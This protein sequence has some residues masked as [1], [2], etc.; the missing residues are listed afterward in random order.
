MQIQSVVVLVLNALAAGTAEQVKGT[1]VQKVITMMNEM[2]AKGKA[3][4]EAETKIFNE[5]AEWV[6]DK[7]RE[8]GFEIKTLKT[9]IEEFTAAAELADADIA[10]LSE[11]IAELDGQI[12]TWEA[13]QKSATAVRD[14]ENAEYQKISKDYK[15]SLDALARAISVLES[16]AVD[17]PQAE[18]L[19]Q[20][21]SKENPALRRV[22]AV[23]LEESE[24]TRTEESLRGAP[25][26]AAYES[27]SGKIIKMLEK[28]KKKVQEG[29][30]RGR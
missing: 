8:T 9:Q 20:K 15:E 10:E 14:S 26:V 19:L 5:Y 27:S 11:K 28:L 17:A 29:I 2:L 16:K 23:F 30:G 6:D 3:E 13:D 21:M 22:V 24:S 25:A 4:K 1:P 12:A 7:S 18:M